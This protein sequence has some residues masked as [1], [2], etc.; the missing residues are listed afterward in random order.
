[1]EKIGIVSRTEQ[2][3]GGTYRKNGDGQFRKLIHMDAPVLPVLN[4]SV[5]R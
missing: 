2:H 1:M 5:G 3:F 4:F